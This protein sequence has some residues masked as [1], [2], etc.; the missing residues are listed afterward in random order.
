[1]TSSSDKRTRS[2]MFAFSP[3]ARTSLRP[4][5]RFSDGPALFEPHDIFLL[6]SPLPCEEPLKD[7]PSLSISSS[8]RDETSPIYSAHETEVIE[9]APQSPEHV[10]KSS[11]CHVCASHCAHTIEYATCSESGCTRIVCKSCFLRFS[12]GWGNLQTLKWKC[13]HCRKQCPTVAHCRISGKPSIRK[14]RRGR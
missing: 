8:I 14:R 10:M 7:F 3:L 1:M 11:W 5:P 6:N 9:R 2:P 12:W 13:V 4:S